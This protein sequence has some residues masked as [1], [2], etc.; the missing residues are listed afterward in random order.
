MFDAESTVVFQLRRVRDAAG[1]HVSPRVVVDRQGVR[2]AAGVD[3]HPA[4]PGRGIA[5]GLAAGHHVHRGV[6]PDLAVGGAGPVDERAVR[7]VVDAGI[8]ADESHGRAG[9]GLDDAFA[10]RPVDLSRGAAGVDRH[11]GVALDPRRIHLAAGHHI[12]AA[13]EFERGLFSGA[14][15]V[16]IHGPAGK[17]RG[18]VNGTAVDIRDAAGCDECKRV[19]LAGEIQS[20]VCADRGL[21]DPPAGQDVHRPAD[22]VARPRGASRFHGYV[23]YDAGILVAVAEKLSALLHRDPVRRA[24]AAVDVH[25]AAFLNRGAACRAAVVNEQLA[26]FA[27]GG[28][29]SGS[30][31]E[32]FHSLIDQRKPG[33]CF[34]VWDNVVCHSSIAFRVVCM[35]YVDLSS[36]SGKIEMISGNIISP[37]AKNKSKKR[38]TGK[39]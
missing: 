21:G 5:G 31:A 9:R 12:H 30:S 39:N 26:V 33:T 32:D 23:S 27:D 15:G 19:R 37:R 38:K 4:G 28:V 35:C 18:T 22:E 25:P 1:R 11:D 2:H 16:D 10:G 8:L 3:I 34:A 7:A 13:A 24:G 36:K 20:S 6:V 29:Q 17:D 14:A